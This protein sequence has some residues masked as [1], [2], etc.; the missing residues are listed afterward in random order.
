M[1]Q[2][3]ANSFKAGFT[4]GADVGTGVG[5]AFAGCW[6]EV[7]AAVAGCWGEED[8]GALQ[9]VSVMAALITL[10]KKQRRPQGVSGPG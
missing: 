2:S 8:A 3:P 10:M 4:A 6:C 9:A 1:R 5:G 7:S